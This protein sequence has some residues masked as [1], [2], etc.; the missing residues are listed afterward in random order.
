M[1]ECRAITDGQQRVGF[2]A[3]FQRCGMADGKDA[4]KG[5]EEATP[6]HEPGDAGRADPEGEE[7]STRDASPLHPRQDRNSFIPPAR[8]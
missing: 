6:R 4:S 2:C 5:G 1:T 3:Q 8:Y 7:L